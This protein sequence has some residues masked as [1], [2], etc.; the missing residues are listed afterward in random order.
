[1]PPGI[2]RAG[3]KSH[4]FP[5]EILQEVVEMYSSCREESRDCLSAQNKTLVQVLTPQY[6]TSMLA[7]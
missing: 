3:I 6:G 5:A 7:N 2:S 1:M 4:S